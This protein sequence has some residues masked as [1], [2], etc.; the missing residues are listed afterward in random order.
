MKH[1]DDDQGDLLDY[2]FYDGTPPHSNESTSLQAAN[3]IEPRANKLRE[4]VR[5]EIANSRDGLTCDEVCAALGIPGNTARP[6]IR[7]LVLDGKV[8]DSGRQRK[9]VSGRNAI[10]WVVLG[11][12]P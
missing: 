3:H 7:E 4:K 9:C 12:T 2:K 6:R 8:V 5:R 1:R 11:A 10:V